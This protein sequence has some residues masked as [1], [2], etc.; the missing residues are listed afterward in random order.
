MAE[1][2]WTKHKLWTA[3]MIQAE[4]DAIND[5]TYGRW[6]AAIEVETRRRIVLSV[7]TYAYEVMDDQ[8]MTDARWDMIA[9]QIN[10][11]LGTC[12][13]IVD[14]FFASQFSPMT[15]MWIHNHPDLAGIKRL[16]ERHHKHP[17]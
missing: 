3:D 17:S 16:Y 7:A 14:E 9:Q 2:D 5:K 10:P 11:K 4:R 12:H 6:G 15:G 13:P 1:I 8:I